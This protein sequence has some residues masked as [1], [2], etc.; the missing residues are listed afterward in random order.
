[1]FNLTILN[2]FIL[3]AWLFLQYILFQFAM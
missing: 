3:V 1:M 2:H